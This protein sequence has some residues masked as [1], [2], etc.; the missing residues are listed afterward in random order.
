MDKQQAI[1]AFFSSF[2]WKAYDSNSVPDSAE[3]PYITYD[4]ITSNISGTVFPAATLN[5][6]SM[7]WE[8]VVQKSNEIAQSLDYG[9]TTIKFDD[10][11]LFITQG[12]PFSQRL[13]DD[14]PGIRKMYLNFAMQFL[15]AY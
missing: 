11:L 2:G 12:S 1:H 15:S 5:D 9:G 6:R 10:G 8:S 7:S 4:A 14:D 13:P 3:L